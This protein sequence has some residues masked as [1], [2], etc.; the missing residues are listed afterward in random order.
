MKYTF[1]AYICHSLDSLT[2]VQIL[3]C[4]S[5]LRVR[6]SVQSH[7]GNRK[8]T[9]S[10][11]PDLLQRCQRRLTKRLYK[12]SLKVNDAV[13]SCNCIFSYR[14]KGRRPGE[15][16]KLKVLYRRRKTVWY[17]QNVGSN[18][19]S[20]MERQELGSPCSRSSMHNIVSGY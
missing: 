15:R 2:T 1:F 19:I 9:S 5:S 14:M 3:L 18:N 7:F 13:V 6:I 12:I 20:C 11:A 10:S 17:V 4:K 16:K 8:G